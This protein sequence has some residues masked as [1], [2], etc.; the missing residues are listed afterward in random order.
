[1]TVVLTRNDGRLTVAVAEDDVEIVSGWMRE[2]RFRTP[3]GEDTV[4]SLQDVVKIEVL[5]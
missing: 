1:M 2:I 4:E 5:L 3:L